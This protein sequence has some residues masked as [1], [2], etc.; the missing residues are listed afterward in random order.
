MVF[1]ACYGIEVKDKVVPAHI[2]KAY[3]GVE[4]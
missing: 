3:R 4:V 1:P 2:I